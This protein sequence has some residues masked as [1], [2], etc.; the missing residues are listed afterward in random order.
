MSADTDTET[1]DDTRLRIAAEL[2]NHAAFD[3]WSKAA[4][5][6][7]ADALGVNRDVA[8]LAFGGSAV[9]MIDA[10]FA[11]VSGSPANAR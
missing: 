5:D 8:Q 7:A 9:A 3:G 4:V 6:A 10:W 1:L 11:T 2:P